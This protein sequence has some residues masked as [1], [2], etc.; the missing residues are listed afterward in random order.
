MSRDK[1]ECDRC[2]STIIAGP[3]EQP[4]VREIVIEGDDPKIYESHS[5]KLCQACE[6]DFLDW[7]DESDV[8]RSSK[9]E[10]ADA[11]EMAHNLDQLGNDL[12]EI[13][14]VLLAHNK[15]N[16]DTPTQE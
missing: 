13:S 2:E 7:I 4:R 3:F 8:D 12:R 11:S 14:E 15:L 6:R 10:L 9:A 16:R 5:R 1:F